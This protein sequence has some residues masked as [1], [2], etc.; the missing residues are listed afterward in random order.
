MFFGF[1]VERGN[2]WGSLRIEGTPIN[3]Q[4]IRVSFFIFKKSLLHIYIKVLKDRGKEPHINILKNLPFFG[5]PF[6]ITHSIFTTVFIPGFKIFFNSLAMVVIFLP[7][8]V[9][10]IFV[11]FYSTLLFITAG[12]NNIVL[13]A[14]TAHETVHTSSQLL[15]SDVLL[16]PCP[17]CR[18]ARQA[19]PVLARTA[20]CH[21][22]SGRCKVTCS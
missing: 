9:F 4:N 22:R 21:G 20:V 3:G 5:T 18:L 7:R 2:D 10:V 16:V 6:C 14:R 1:K 13:L 11:K 17:G 15:R 12:L 8:D 19:R